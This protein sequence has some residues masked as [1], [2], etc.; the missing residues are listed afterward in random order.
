MKNFNDI[1]SAWSEREIPR[2]PE[3]GAQNIV[4]KVRFIKKKQIMGQAVLS[5]T[6]MIL[7]WFF[8]YISAF[9]DRQVSLGLI[10]MVGALLLRIVV[11]FIF[12]MKLI[13]FRTESSIV[14]FQE[15]IERYFKSR[16]WIHLLVTPILFVSYLIGFILL[17]PAFKEN[18]SSGFYTYILI[19]SVV[20]FIVLAIFIGYHAKKELKLLKSMNPGDL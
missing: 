15:Q 14:V 13:K 5:T 4:R 6:V 16:L 19:S 7:I 9:N 12:R 3:D 10:I 2:A 8:F 18:L 17:L 11:E 1:K 20:I